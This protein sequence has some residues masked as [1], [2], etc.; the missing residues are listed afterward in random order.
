MQKDTGS[1]CTLISEDMWNSIGK[2]KLT[3]YRSKKLTTYGDDEIKV[4]G[5]INELCCLY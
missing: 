2:P 4:I 3:K 5:L 1:S